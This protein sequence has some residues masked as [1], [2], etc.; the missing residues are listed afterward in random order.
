VRRIEAMAATHGFALADLRPPDR[1][2]FGFVG[3]YR[4]HPG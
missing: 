3:A 4:G 2:E 1:Q